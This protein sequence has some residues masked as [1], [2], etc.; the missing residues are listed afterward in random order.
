MDKLL[1]PPQPTPPPAPGVAVKA[2]AL[3]R[4]GNLLLIEHGGERYQ[5]RLTRSG[6]LILT[7]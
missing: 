3:M 7:K 1:I 5:L 6:K 4:G 2:A